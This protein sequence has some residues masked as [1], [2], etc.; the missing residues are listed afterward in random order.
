MGNIAES[1]VA[2]KTTE[3]ERWETLEGLSV[4]PKGHEQPGD[5]GQV[6]KN[7]NGQETRLRVSDSVF[8]RDQKI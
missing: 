3:T 8:D 4:K 6:K 7:K 5:N 2:G 1:T